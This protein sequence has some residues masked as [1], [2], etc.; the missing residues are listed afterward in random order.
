MDSMAE[1]FDNRL[2]RLY[3]AIVRRDEHVDVE[4]RVQFIERDISEIKQR[5]AA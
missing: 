2:N 5:L 1:K 3:E 4:R